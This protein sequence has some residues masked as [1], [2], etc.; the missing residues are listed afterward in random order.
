MMEQKIDILPTDKVTLFK[1]IVIDVFGIS[2]EIWIEQMTQEDR[3]RI[4]REAKR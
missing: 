3:D 2:R 4:R 1:E